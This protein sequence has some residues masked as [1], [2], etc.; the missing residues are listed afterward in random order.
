MLAPGKSRRPH[1]SRR[2]PSSMWQHQIPRAATLTSMCVCNGL[3]ASSCAPCEFASQVTEHKCAGHGGHLRVT[4]VART[5]PHH[6]RPCCRPAAAAR[7]MLRGT[8][9]MSDATVIE[10]AETTRDTGMSTPAATTATGQQCFVTRGRGECSAPSC[11]TCT[12]N[13]SSCVDQQNADTDCHMS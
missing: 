8:T 12:Y 13:T 4:G 3:N 1:A 7:S 9:G 6:S 10:R 2:G 5:L 11:C